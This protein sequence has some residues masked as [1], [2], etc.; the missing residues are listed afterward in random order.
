MRIKKHT[1]FK[2]LTFLLVFSSINVYS[3][4]IALIARDFE[5]PML[6]TDSVSAEQVKSGYFPIEKAN[7]DTFYANVKYLIDMLKIRQRAKMQSFELRS[8][9]ST[10]KVSRVPYSNGDRYTAIA[11]NKEDEIEAIMP[12]I[13]HQISNKKSAKRLQLLLDYLTNNKSLFTKPYGIT[14]KI[15][16][17]AVITE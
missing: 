14:P 13:D 8:G 6:F 11:K 4:K 1:I 17:V 15:Y 3:Q 2:I 9:T 12:L 5:R 7:I 16:N 10:I